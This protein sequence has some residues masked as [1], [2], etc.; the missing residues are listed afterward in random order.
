MYEAVRADNKKK[1]GSLSLTLGD[2]FFCIV[3]LTQ[4]ASQQR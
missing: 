1:T 4:S 3:L 2:F